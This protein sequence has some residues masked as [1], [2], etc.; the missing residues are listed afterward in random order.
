MRVYV[1]VQPTP[2]GGS[3]SLGSYI[4]KSK[5]D[6]ER[7][8]LTD[9]GAR[10]LFSA[11]KDNLTVK[12]ADQIL[13]P[14]NKQL[15]KEELIHV[16]ISPEPGSLDRAGDEPSQRHKTIREAIRTTVRAMERV[17]KVK[18]LL[19]IAGLH[20]NTKTPHVHVAVSRWA[21]DAA[22]EKLR[23]IKHLPKTLLPHNTEDAGGERKFLAGKIAEVF[24]SSFVRL[25]RPIRSVQLRDT[26]NKIDLS[27]STLSRFAQLLQAP[28]TEQVTVGK[29]VETALMLATN[30]MGELS[31]EELSRQYSELTIEVSKID[32][33]AQANGE[34]PPAA[35]IPVERLETLVNA[36]APDAQ[37]AVSTN[38]LPLQDEKFVAV[39]GAEAPAASNESSA[40]ITE[41]STELTSPTVLPITE[42]VN[43]KQL[44]GNEPE[45][46]PSATAHNQE[47]QER[48]PD[49]PKENQ[50]A[51]L[52]IKTTTI[53]PQEPERIGKLT[54][55]DLRNQIQ[56]GTVAVSPQIISTSTQ[57]ERAG[58]VTKIGDGESM[59]GGPVAP[60]HAVVPTHHI[61]SQTAE[62]T[63]SPTDDS[64]SVD[65]ESQEWELDDD[66][67]R[68]FAGM[69]LWH[70][71]EVLRDRGLDV[72][73]ASLH[74]DNN[75]Q[76]SQYVTRSDA[77]LREAQIVAAI[78]QNVCRERK[79]VP[80][81]EGA[82]N[83]LLGQVQQGNG[84]IYSMCQQMNNVRDYL[85]ELKTPANQRLFDEYERLH[86]LYPD[87][88]PRVE[89][90]DLYETHERSLGPT[91]RIREHEHEREQEMSLDHLI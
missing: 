49:L 56:A 65:P 64:H 75:H 74:I 87:L 54:L 29:W 34:R 19:W 81:I 60:P 38:Q 12:E 11:H 14:T 32:A 68:R 33:I 86:T 45:R 70:Y 22:T 80:D 25:L 30:R 90:A 42:T 26:K 58:A 51:Q 31:A 66:T 10:P 76:F 39:I 9:A 59:V 78:C 44:A 73:K 5:I 85:E 46:M 71:G 16:V 37:I 91:E 7:E 83:Y 20:E 88:T 4:A 77:V 82:K 35:Y 48:R 89:H 8:E 47:R 36:K 28:T 72:S 40:N 57:H 1:G 69:A 15:E 3:S 53:R 52:A 13:N 84:W 24:V 62:S 63:I 41:L 18:N 61:Q 79:L 50:T 21:L 17:L 67:V 43:D 2:Q 23:Y 6:R 55:T 27:R